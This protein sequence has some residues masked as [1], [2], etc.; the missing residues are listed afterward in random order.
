MAQRREFGLALG[1]VVVHE[2][3]HALAPQRPHVKGGL[4][5][6][7]MGRAL[8]LASDI[9]I[10]AGTSEALRAAVS[11]RAPARHALAAVSELSRERGAERP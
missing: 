3:V 1:R 6:D 7:R 2:L 9:V 5:A 11:G 10:D 8:L 4:M